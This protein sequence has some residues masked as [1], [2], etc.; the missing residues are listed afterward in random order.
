VLSYARIE[1]RRVEYD[2]RPVSLAE[3]VRD[4][5]AMVEPQLAAKALTFVVDLADPSADAAGATP[6]RVWAD[7][8]K[9]VQV[10]LNLLSNAVKFT[11]AGGGVTVTLAP[12]PG[13]PTRWRWRCATTASASRRRST[14]PSSSRSCRRTAT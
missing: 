4:V 12:V 2:V 14:R 1:A 3:L 13:A 6:G 8:E 7:R 5:T 11:P 9:L 10:L